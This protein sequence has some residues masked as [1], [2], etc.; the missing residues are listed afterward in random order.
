MPFFVST[1]S[2]NVSSYNVLGSELLWVQGPFSLQSEAMM[3]VVNQAGG[4]AAVLPGMYAQAGYF[5]TGE[6]R[7]YDRKT[8]TIDRVIPKSNLTFNGK[9]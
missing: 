9:C 6:H 4:G 3:N 2:L 1:G 5:L 7:P 8:G